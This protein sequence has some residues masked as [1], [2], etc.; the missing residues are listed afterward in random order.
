MTRIREMHSL[1]QALSEAPDEQVLRAVAMVDALAERGEA[2]RLIQPLRARLARIR[3]A[4]PLSF[5]RLLFTPL[6]PVIVSRADW[7]QSGPGIPRPALAALAQAVREGWPADSQHQVAELDARLASLTSADT[8]ELM[9]LGGSVWAN[10]ARI[11][12]VA[13]IP[14]D[15]RAT[16]GLT[17]IDHACLVAGAMP[18]MARAPQI[19]SLWAYATDMAALDAAL[20][21]LLTPS[22]AIGAA[23]QHVASPALLAVL[24]RRAPRADRVL[25]VARTIDNGHAQADAQAALD[26]LL[27]SLVRDASTGSLALAADTVQRAGPLLHD[28]GRD[29]AVVPPLRRSLQEVRDALDAVSRNRL[30]AA[31]A[32]TLAPGPAHAASPIQREGLARDA[33]RLA[34]AARRLSA[35]AAYDEVMRVC[36]AGLA[37]RADSN[38][39]RARL[40]EILAAYR[41]SSAFVS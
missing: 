17:D 38:D 6:D 22:T 10:A 2:D 14:D 15:W 35:S 11:L 32:D 16:V 30:S 1:T 19:L 40:A 39:E 18:I 20:F 29:P 9:A 12:A 34:K 26:F 3:P 36:V 21:A 25:A 23:A 24:L 13:P 4:R 33:S 27:D 31:L 37:D 7:L 5:T 28:L 8:V 41:S